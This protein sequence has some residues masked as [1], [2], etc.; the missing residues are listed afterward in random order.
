MYMANKIIVSQN[1][2]IA[3]ELKNSP[4]EKYACPDT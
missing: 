4:R 1:P 2:N 3:V